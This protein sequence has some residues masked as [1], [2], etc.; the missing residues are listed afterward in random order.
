[1][2]NI[3]MESKVDECS[4][5]K[6]SFEEKSPTNTTIKLAVHPDVDCF[7]SITVQLQNAISQSNSTKTLGIITAIIIFLPALIMFFRYKSAVGQNRANK[8]VILH[9][10]QLC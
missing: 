1:M 5:M 2:Y 10:L 4:S 7:Y 8:W 6:Y 3:F 9:S